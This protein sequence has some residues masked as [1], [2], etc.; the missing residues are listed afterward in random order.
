VKLSKSLYTKGIQCPKLLW[1]KKF[2]KEALT[3][4]GPDAEERFRTGDIVGGLACNLFPGGQEVPYDSDDYQGMIETTRLWMNQGVEHIYEATFSYNGILVMVDIFRSTPDGVE[5]YEV[6]SSTE[7]KDIYK[8]DASIQY[9]VLNS[10]GLNVKRV[11]IVHLDKSYVRDGDLELG[12]MFHVEDVTDEV[13]DMQEGVVN[14]LSLFTKVLS[15]RENEPVTDIGKHCK[16]PYECEAKEYCWKVQKGIPE[17]SIFNIF[18][19]GTKK[20]ET[21]YEKGIVCIEDIP[22]D[23]DLTDG[24]YLKVKNWKKQAPY[25]DKES[26][27]SFLDS[28][29]YP[30]YHLDF[31][32]FQPAIPPWDNVSPNQRIPFQYSLHIQHEDGRLEHRE[33]LAGG[34]RDPRYELANRLVAD[35][36]A[37]VTVLAYHMSFEKG[38]IED[39]A[40]SYEDLSVSLRKINDNM[41]DLELPFSKGYYWVPA[42]QGSSSIKQVLPALVPTMELAYKDL[43]G[44]QN[45]LEAMTVFGKMADMPTEDKEQT[46]KSLLEYCKLDTLAMVKILEVLKRSVKDGSVQ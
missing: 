23:F 8:H 24:Q 21:L 19:M 4:P 28:L 5:I 1:L 6:K 12:K 29:H 42:M 17:Y 22:D 41:K 43:D 20:Q 31:E 26:V 39:L 10:L 46:R 38:V 11:C 34:D 9:H 36:P 45:G 3:P 33:Y 15:D 40:K 25:M 37:D 30:I 44:V 27:Q 7:L 13:V 16:K 35:I 14:S 2:N 32:T 18:N